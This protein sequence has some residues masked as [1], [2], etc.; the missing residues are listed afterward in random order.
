MLSGKSNPSNQ[1]PS[2][3]STYP[4]YRTSKATSIVPPIEEDGSQIQHDKTLFQNWGKSIKNTPVYT[5]FPKT[6]VGVANIVTWANQLGKR[7]RVSG[8]Q[9]TEARL[10]SDDNQILI[11]LISDHTTDNLS[12]PHSPLNRANQL[13]DIQLVG[14]VFKENGQFK[15][16]C[17]IG[18]A[19]TNEQFRQWVMDRFYKHGTPHTWTLPLNVTLLE[20]TF[21]GTNALI[22]HGSGLANKTISD[23]VTEIEFI[24]PYGQLQTVGY[25]ITDPVDL[26][27][28]GQQLIKTA[29][30][31]FGLLGVVTSMTFKL[32]QLT[33]ARMRPKKPRLALAV[34]PPKG[35]E[36]PAFLPPYV[37]QDVTETQL[38]EATN[39]FISDC[40]TNYYAEWLWCSLHPRCWVNS[41][42][43]NGNE[44][45][46]TAYPHS[47]ESNIQQINEYVAELKDHSVI[48]RLPAKWQASL[49]SD[50]AML[51]LPAEE[52]II[53]PLINGIHFC[54]DIPA[55]RAQTMEFEIPIPL[56]ENGKPDWSICQRAWWDAIITVYEW[57]NKTDSV[58]MR[59]PLAMRIMG[60]SDITMAAQRGNTWGTCSIQMLTLEAGLVDQKEWRAFVQD[61][62]DKWASYTD[63]QGNPLN[64][65]PHWATDWD[66]LTIQRPG[67]SRKKMIHYLKEDAYKE[68][69]PVFRQHLDSIAAKGGYNLTELRLFSNPLLDTLVFNI[70]SAKNQSTSLKPIEEETKSID[71]P[72]EKEHLSSIYHLIK[73]AEK[74]H[75]AKRQCIQNNLNKEGNIE[76]KMWPDNLTDNPISPEKTI[77]AWFESRQK[78][79]E[80]KLEAL[81]KKVASSWDS[82]QAF[83]NSYDKK[84]NIALVESVSPKKGWKCC[85]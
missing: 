27:T 4:Q 3:A 26:Q 11:S 13:Q 1:T 5:F 46:S 83:F 15:H 72:M 54:H 62:T 16:L 21:G 71:A 38:Q 48:Q 81:E 2:Q 63:Y 61:V 34:P 14:K 75:I 47:S 80:D 64:I 30:G 17:K 77:I 42:K 33:H 43:N 69:L 10:F 73:K 29:A 82:R 59:L 58:P 74:S 76:E 67:E 6:K 78:E 52:D 18:A 9:Y 79:E 36:L 8:Y 68:V 24:N 85:F 70:P 50:A 41:W 19:T 35:F 65:R 45:R 56:R 20:N 49:L 31:C 53:T 25:H 12:S 23:L 66:G 44:N 22:C 57:L 84:N 60:D 32:D 28:E 7:V 40:E 51:S 37:M 55:R 39:R